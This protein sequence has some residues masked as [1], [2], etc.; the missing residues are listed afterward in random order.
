MYVVVLIT[1]CIGSADE[2]CCSTNRYELY[3]GDSLI[4][5]S[6]NYYRS[7][8]IGSWCHPQ[9]IVRRN[10][11]ENDVCSGCTLTVRFQSQSAGHTVLTP[12][13]KLSLYE[14]NYTSS[15]YYLPQ[16]IWLTSL[17][18]HSLLKSNTTSLQCSTSSSYATI[19]TSRFS[20]S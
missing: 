12:G 18:S 2:N 19:R 10:D 7:G 1:G 17:V 15:S 20:L 16:N 4:L 11:M 9:V 14:G 8:G 3:S 6:G 5:R 13:S